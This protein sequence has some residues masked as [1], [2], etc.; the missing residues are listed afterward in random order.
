MKKIVTTIGLVTLLALMGSTAAYAETGDF[1]VYPTYMHGDNKNWILLDAHQGTTHNDFITVENLTDEPQTIQL[2]VKEAKEENGTYL[3]IEDK[4]YEA[5]GLWT[6]LS[7]KTLTLMPF[8]KRTVETTI[9]IPEN[10]EKKEHMATILAS[11]SETNAENIKITTRIGVR[12]Y[13]S[14]DDNPLLQAN[15]FNTPLYKNTFFFILSFIGV[16]ATIFY[17]FIHYL[18]NNKNKYEK[19]HA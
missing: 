13:V 9:K 12:M 15:I 14:V 6:E 11:K 18:E 8:E 7:E 1:T 16:L 2:Q 19:K 10:A 17:N 5:V 3:P 4:E